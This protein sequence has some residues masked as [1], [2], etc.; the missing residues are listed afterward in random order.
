MPTEMVYLLDVGV[1]STSML[2]VQSCIWLPTTH[3]G[4]PKLNLCLLR[5][6]LEIQ[7]EKIEFEHAVRVSRWA[8][9][10]V[11]CSFVCS[12]L[13]IAMMIDKLSFQYLV[14]RISGVLYLRF[15]WKI[16]LTRSTAGI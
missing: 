14:P 6:I 15:R 7:I 2:D 5:L 11:C 9:R 16:I 1:S 3:S 13:L 4:F 10:C 12:C 8:V